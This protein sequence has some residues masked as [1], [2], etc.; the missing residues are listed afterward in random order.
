VQ[1][2]VYARPARLK[3]GWSLALGILSLFV[4]FTI[5]PPVLGFVLGLLAL[6]SEPAARGAAIAGVI[7]N[8][9]VLLALVGAV[10]FAIL[11]LAIA[12]AGQ[13]PTTSTP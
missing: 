13:E 1:P 12:I 3:A 8:G 10:A 5:V 7:L 6:K 11:M 2:I 4:G 9:L